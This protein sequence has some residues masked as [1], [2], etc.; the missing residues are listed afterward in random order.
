MA[1]WG[2]VSN[3]FIELGKSNETGDYWLTIH[4]G[5]RNFGKCIADYHQKKAVRIQNTPLISKEDWV[6]Q[7]KETYP[8]DQ[9][10]NK[11]ARYQEF[12]GR[13]QS[14]KGMEYLEGNHMYEYLVHMVIAQFY[15]DFNRKVMMDEILNVMTELDIEYPD[16]GEEIITVHNFIDFDDWIIRKGAIRSYEGEKA[17]LPFNMEDGLVIIEGKSNPEWNCSAP[18]GAG[19]L[20]SRSEAKRR[21]DLDKAK[22]SMNNKGIYS[23]GIPHDEVKG[24]YKDPETIEMCIEPT[25]TIID[26]IKPVVNLKG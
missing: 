14:P 5:S 11:I 12:Y 10:A 26:R 22:E 16:F 21:L 4:S 20:F 13:K 3:H 9:W 7:V 18:H 17:V 24:A 25:A 2:A 15:A 6:C 8:K 23:S 19:R 1:P